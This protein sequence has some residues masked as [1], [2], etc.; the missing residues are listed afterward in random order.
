MAPVEPK[1]KRTIVFI[2][3]QNLYY[4]AKEAF[5]Y[6]YP[7]YD[8]NLLSKK[9]CSN[10]GW[11]IEKIRFYTGIPDLQDDGFWNNFWHNKLTRMGQDGIKIFS[12]P[13]RYHNQTFKCPSCS[14]IHTSLV[15]HEKGIDV[16]MALDVIRLAHTKAYDVVLI[17]SQDQDLSEV[18]EEIRLIANEQ[19]RW[20]K[21]ASAF[22]V[23][24]TYNNK[25]GID[26]TDWIKIDRKT[27]D[28]CIDP[29]DY[30]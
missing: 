13:L 9:I 22:L 17:I 5:G 18:A 21:I 27:Y 23:S 15:G 14:K 26:K 1:K 30:R 8:V 4:V 20:I 3:G 11:D 10:Q 6:I 7:N 2:D 28:A 12:R 24:P 16:R 25:R 29:N 19:N